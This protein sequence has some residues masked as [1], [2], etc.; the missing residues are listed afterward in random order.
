MVPGPN[1]EAT[2]LEQGEG[3]VRLLRVKATTPP[4]ALVEVAYESACGHCEDDGM[5]ALPGGAFVLRVGGVL[6]HWEP[7]K[8]ARRIGQDGLDT[9]EANAGLYYRTHMAASV[10]GKVAIAGARHV[11]RLDLTTGR[12]TAVVGAGTPNLAGTSPDTSLMR[13]AGLAVAPN[14]DLLITDDYARQ[15]KRVPAAAW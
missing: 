12:P 4:V 5:A 10:D 1:G 9:R 8:A 2:V 7:G 6:W 11:Y 13:V 15:V 3:G 14:G